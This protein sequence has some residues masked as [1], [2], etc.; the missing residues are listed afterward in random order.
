[1]DLISRARWWIAAALLG[2]ATALAQVK[3]AQLPV[4]VEDSQAAQDLIEQAETL[5]AQDRLGEAAE[6]Y[7]QVV[8]QYGGKLLSA[9]GKLYTDARQRVFEEVRVD[10][11]LLTAYRRLTEP[12][13]QRALAA[14]S[15]TNPDPAA[16]ETLLANDWLCQVGL[17]AGLRLAAI[18]LERGRT[19]DAA[20]LLDQLERHPDLPTQAA[21]WHLLQAAAALFGEQ[22]ARLERHQLALQNLDEQKALATLAAWQRDAHPPKA[23]PALDPTVQLPAVKLPETLPKPLWQVAL[24]DSGVGESAR[25]SL[26]INNRFP[27]GE[28]ESTPVLRPV[29]V[30]AG[31]CVYINSGNAVQAMDLL[32][33]RVSWIYENPQPATPG[34]NAWIRFNSTVPD[35]RSVLLEGGQV[36]AVLG[37]ATPGPMNFQMRG[38]GTAVTC[39]AADDGRVLWRIEP[40]DIDT[41]LATAFFHGTPLADHGRIFVMVRR[42]QMSGFQDAYLVALAADTGQTLWRRYLSSAVAANRYISGPMS[43][44]LLDSGRLYV[45]DNLGA[46]TCLDP[47]SGTVRWLS[48]LPGQPSELDAVV[49]ARQT[50]TSLEN[51]RPVLVEAGLIVPGLNP[52]GAACLLDP[53]TGR[54]L[55]DLGDPAFTA[56]D[57]FT[58]A[59]RDVLCVGADVWLLDGRTLQKRWT[60][61]LGAA[62][63]GRAALTADRILLPL[64]DRLLV[65]KLQ[66]GQE[67]AQYPLESPGTLLALAGQLLVVDGLSLRSHMDWTLAYAKLKERAA[68]DRLDPMPGLALAHLAQS[69]GQSAA[70]LEGADNALEALRRRGAGTTDRSTNETLQREVFVQLLQLASAASG[71]IEVNLRRA[72]FDRLASATGSPADEVSYQFAFGQFLAENGK[73]QEAVDHYQAV[74]SDPT[75]TAQLYQRGTAARQAGLEA[76]LRLAALIKQAGAA[77][78]QRYEAMASQR[79]TELTASGRGDATALLDVARQFPIAQAAPAALLAAA[80]SLTA[81]GDKEGAIEQLRRAYGYELEPAMLQR[82]VGRL[83]E[84][85]ASTNRS[86]QARHWLERAKRE[87]AGLQPLRDGK[88]VEMDPWLAELA[89]QPTGEMPLPALTLPLGEPRV[90]AG[91]LATPIAQAEESW[92]R[93]R[94]V[95]QTAGRVQLRA[96]P[97]LDVLWEAAVPS[98]AAALLALGPEQTLFWLNQSSTLLALDSKTGRPLWPQ[99]DAKATL[100]EVGGQGQRQAAATA[101]QRRFMEM[102]NPGLVVV[103]PRGQRDPTAGTPGYILKVNEAVICLADRAGR[104]VG[105]ER[106]SG[107]ILWRLL[108]PM[109][110]LQQVELSDEGLVLTGITGVQTDAPSG[111]VMVLDPVTGEARLPAVEE[112]KPVLWAGLGP[113]GLLIRVTQ[114]EAVAQHLADGALAWRLGLTGNVV[115]PLG[116]SGGELLFIQQDN[117]GLLVIEAATGQILNR[118][119]DIPGGIAGRVKLRGVEQRWHLLS[120]GMAGA[121]GPEGQVQWRDAV[122]SGLDKQFLR[123]LIGERYVVILAMARGGESADMRAAAGPAL[124]APNQPAQ[125]VRRINRNGGVEIH[126]EVRQGQAVQIAP[127][128]ANDAAEALPL[129][130]G[131]GWAYRLLFLDRQSGLLVH[132]RTIAPLPVALDPS[133]ATFL[134]NCLVLSTS[135]ATIVIPGTGK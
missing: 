11:D 132:D 89:R 101:E 123:Q 72:L 128:A 111:I 5:R 75:L 74:L 129:E 80:E 20:A 28:R 35:Q 60:H 86:R 17:E 130:R 40:K 13:A 61:K 51:T 55:R 24:P 37:S 46:V 93:D 33:G 10:A 131:G 57:Y 92:P 32:S 109:E 113:E 29:P 21:R 66:D 104:V 15:A 6:L 98:T 90:L 3:I 85:Y 45:A 91:R 49:R 78:Y 7:H 118:I 1:M 135:A 70:M 22:P 42:S 16:L 9:G 36:V 96:G 134:D 52:N 14:Q 124:V 127:G 119:A 100:E 97:R 53:A 95:T 59:G 18:E 73:P 121:V 77:I 120:A 87:H 102:V 112:K 50:P 41:S 88:P 27:G 122:L 126:V 76:R 8:T 105:I 34:V 56:C 63:Q 107:R 117:E 68:A 47:R 26:L 30:A 94:I 58:R 2:A 82:T 4:Y 12:A 64:R 99:L 108:C 103:G 67:E 83:V 79:L 125:I 43:Q 106:K 38:A 69:A 114:T 71:S 54:R 23:Q 116:Q 62:P 19:A 81:T 31:S 39:L 25:S 48:V 110:P 65:L 133:R 84:L 115:T 44:M